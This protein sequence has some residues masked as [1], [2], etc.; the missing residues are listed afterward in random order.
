MDGSNT[1]PAKVIRQF[2]LIPR[3]KCMWR[4]SDIAGM[5]TGYRKHISEDGVMRLVV[6][7]PA[8]KH[9]DGHV[10]FNNFGSEILNMRLTLALDGVNPFKLSNTIGQRGPF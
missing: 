1:I 2:P 4:S 5:L 8:W 6:D 3:L 9:I 7:S 10:A